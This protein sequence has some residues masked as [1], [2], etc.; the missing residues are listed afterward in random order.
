[1]TLLLRGASQITDSTPLSG[2]AYTSIAVPSGSQVGDLVVIALP[3]AG[4]THSYSLD[5]DAR[6]SAAGPGAWVG[7]L[8][9][10]GPFAVSTTDPN[11]SNSQIVIA[12]FAPRPAPAAARWSVTTSSDTGTLGTVNLPDAVVIG[13]TTHSV[14]SGAFVLADPQASLTVSAPPNNVSARIYTLDYPSTPSPALNWSLLGGSG[15]RWITVIGLG[16]TGAPPCRLHPRPDHLGVGSGRV[17]PPPGTR[18][19]GRLNGP[20]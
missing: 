4:A 18:Q 6:V 19:A 3:P 17:W 11:G 2:P 14:V 10:L 12:V 16:G 20:Y 1:M 15:T 8:T 9:H 5:A 13:C 7:T